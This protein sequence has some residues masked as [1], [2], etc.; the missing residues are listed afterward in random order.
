VSEILL[1]NSTLTD[2]DTSKR[3]IDLIAVPWDQEAT[4][5]W[6]DDWWT[7][8][9]TRGAFK[10][11]ESRA[12]EVRVNREHT[13]GRTV[14]RIDAFDPSHPNGLWARVKVVKGPTGDEVLNLAEDDMISASVTALPSRATSRSTGRRNAAQF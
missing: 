11:I 14:G 5:Y 7:E 6:R 3:Q 13:K 9:F 12:G 8:V 1:R 2:V 10:D 4:V